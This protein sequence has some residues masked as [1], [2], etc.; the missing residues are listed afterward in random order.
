MSNAIPA[1][2]LVLAAALS[3]SP[4]SALSPASGQSPASAQ[5]PAEWDIT[6]PRG[7]TREIAF[8]TTEGTWM[9]VD[10]SPDGEWLVFDL[11]G[12]IYRM[13][14]GGGEAASITQ[15]SGLALNIH[16][17]FSPDG[18]EIAFISDREGQNNLW[19]MNADGTDPRAVFTNI[20]IRAMEPVWTP[21]G[22]YIVVRQTDMAGGGLFSYGLFMYHRD[23]GTG[24]E[25][26][27]YTTEMPGWPSVSPDGR[28]LYF[29]QFVGSI[30][31]YG[32]QDSSSGD[33]Q[34][35]RLELATGEITRITSGQSQQ[36]GRMTSGGAFA[37]E[38]SP[39]GRFL[40]F[41]RRIPDGLLEYRGHVF[42]PRT[43]LWLRDL[44]D[45][46]ERLVMDPVEWD[47][48]QEI[49]RAAPILPRFT[50][51]ADGRRIYLSQG[52]GIRVLDPGSGSVGTVPFT[53]SVQRTISEM[54]YATR[55]IPEGTFDA[56]FLRW[57]TGSRDGRHIV[58][59]GVGKL[60]IQDAAG[61]EPRRLTPG[62]FVGF[63][64]A[65][66]WS[67]NGTEIAFT[68]FDWAEGG[69][70]WRIPADGG[71]PTR[72]SDRPAEYMNPVWS[73]DGSEILV[74]RSAGA[75]ARGRTPEDN[76]WHELVRFR[77]AGGGGGGAQAGPAGGT[78]V[79]RVPREMGALAPLASWGEDG[80]I[81]FV[82]KGSL[83][84]VTADGADRREHVRLPASVEAVASPDAT[85]VAFVTVGDVFVAPLPSARSS[86]AVPAISRNAGS[87]PVTRLTTEGG[88]FPR[89]RDA[90]TLEFGSGGARYTTHDLASG[91]TSSADL[92]LT[93]PRNVPEGSVAITNARV[94]TLDEA[95]V[96]EG[97]D[98]VTAQGRIVCVGSCD[99]SGAD[100]TIDGTGKTV[101]PGWIDVHGHHNRQSAG[102]LPERGFEHA[103][104]LAYGVTTTRD[105]AAW[106]VN[107]WSTK[108]L[109]QARA[110]IGPRIYAT[111]E[112]LT[113]GDT[114]W[115]ADVVSRE[116]A[117]H[118]AAR[119][120]N[121][122]AESIKQYLQPNRRRAQWLVDAARE[123]GMIAT[124]EGG[125]FDISH[126]IGL[127]MDGHAGFEHALVQFPIYSDVSRFLGQAGF[128]YSPT[129]VV[130]G[131][132]PWAEE[133][134]FQRE[135]TWLDEKS[136]RWLPWRHL[137]PH[138]RRRM[139]RPETDYGFSL[140]AEGLADV[141]AAGGYGGIGSHGQQH[142]PASHWE[143]WMYAEA[144][145][146]L[147]ALEVASVHG[148][149]MI[150]LQKELGSL[151]PGKYADLM[152]LGSNPLDD[153]ENT[154]DIDLVMKDGV[155][156]D[157]ATMDEVWPAPRPFGPYYWVN[158]DIMKTDTLPVSRWRPG[159]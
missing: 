66:A 143:V 102:L 98:V 157:A 63:E 146:P 37:P 57:P 106:S 18:S 31:P 85:H 92:R 15:N 49:T 64:Y 86:D 118:Q 150:G 73:P 41:G 130:G 20:N 120:Q 97:A 12:H 62:S 155:V 6:M 122:G 9:S 138:A 133:Y 87:L 21:D 132:S 68:T 17:V 152:V 154:L 109:V 103:A 127:V 55:S 46:T 95:G 27:P 107:T 13:P 153:I 2:L 77:A 144:L 69:H 128:Y 125:N 32:G 137:I 99:T 131:S 45:G 82:S 42:G 119:L 110:M 44:E 5:S 58:F 121:W 104:Y 96:I 35:R 101:I 148:A 113:A 4:A 3:L 81:Y 28:Y 7:E 114:P 83:V 25:L 135:D 112:T 16:P 158:D 14:A 39:D 65:P 147:G 29:H 123:R 105:P 61:G 151:A 80:R 129:V 54:A 33:F 30:L 116:D 59:E 56:R 142:G 24:I 53:A 88:L 23:G 108:D 50:W 8:T 10:L 84:S 76:P 78:A 1:T 52:G 156:Y 40:V 26:V 74:A 145:G 71:E 67:P 72:V 140:V 124:S 149:R 11:L 126:N 94:V 100:H 38:V 91:E 22:Q 111:G 34:I 51:S 141:I 89:W 136:R 60:W 117:D 134:F 43:G 48:S 115:K 47:M 93:V 75:T 139:M 70:L 36:Q 90:S 79:A 19:I 159:N